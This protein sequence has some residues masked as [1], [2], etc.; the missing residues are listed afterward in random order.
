M[1]AKILIVLSRLNVKQALYV[2]GSIL[3]ACHSKFK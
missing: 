1:F 2:C 3:P